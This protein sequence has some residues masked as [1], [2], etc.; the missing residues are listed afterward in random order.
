M[1]EKQL[2]SIIEAIKEIKVRVNELE[3]RTFDKETSTL[4][5]KIN[6]LSQETKGI[7]TIIKEAVKN[8]VTE[9]KSQ[10]ND[11]SDLKALEQQLLKLDKNVSLNVESASNSLK[12]GLNEALE[13]IDKLKEELEDYKDKLEEYNNKKPL[14]FKGTKGER[15]ADGAPG[16]NG[17]DGQPGTNGTN[18][19]NGTNGTNG[20]DGAQGPR[21]FT[22]APGQDGIVYKGTAEV[23]FGN[24]PGTNYIEVL[25]NDVNVLST[26]NV[27]I[28][29]GDSTTSHNYIEHML[30]GTR[31]IVTD[32]VE[33]VSFKVQV[34]S[35][36]R[37]T[38]TFKINYT[39][40]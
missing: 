6:E 16:I 25:I 15:G 28:T 29:M 30:V 32:V 8:S 13:D 34:Y 7:H 10:V 20:Q 40:T 11:K 39:I 1:N 37:L 23:N 38:G 12:I 2:L 26:S 36:L 5:N 27:V 9:L 3:G 31:F 14:V 17:Q 4:T 24:A 35:D 21:G 18:G 22:G 33:G 19:I